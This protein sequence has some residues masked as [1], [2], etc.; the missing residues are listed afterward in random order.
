M[1]RS[2]PEVPP[3]D[4]AGSTQADNSP[5][6]IRVARLDQ[7]RHPDLQALHSIILREGPRSRREAK[8]TAIKNRHT[9]EA[10]HDS[11][12]IKSYKKRAGDWREDVEHSVTLSSDGGIDEIQ[13]LLDF[14]LAV[15][16]GA[17]PSEGSDYLLITARA[18]TSSASGLHRALNALSATDQVDVLT[19]VLG[20]VAGDPN[21]LRALIKRAA[22]D[23]DLFEEAATALNLA[24]YHQ[25]V[26]K[27]KALTDQQNVHEMEFQ[28]LLEAHP[29]MFGSEYS[30]VLDRRRWTRDEQ[31]D[32]IVRRT[33]DGY[34]EIIEIKT[35]LNG[36]PLFL[37]D[38]S[39][40]SYYSCAHLSKVVGQV[41]KYIER[42]DS[43]RHMIMAQ[44]GEDTAKIRAKIIIGRSGDVEQ[45]RAL[46]RF[47][48]HL[49]RIEV[50]TFDQ[51]LRITQQ[52]TS[53]LRRA[54]RR[55]E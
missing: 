25:A 17:V 51:L 12:T 2:R 6:A 28:K 11:I 26:L 1:N 50:I 5:L 21:L 53:Y 8:Y 31:Q 24:N 14:M 27:L 54:L 44:D 20:Q 7:E 9:G 45:Q 42:L 10:H 35:P 33:T 49:H 19:D 40:D 22:R 34:I 36:A 29:W 48:G 47:N 16:N 4:A 37:H 38:P 52:V 43:E 13:K 39:H 30:E 15:R 41:Q 46:H 3:S 18:G 23:P 32:F 55:A